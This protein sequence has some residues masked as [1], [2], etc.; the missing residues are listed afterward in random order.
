MPRGLLDHS[1]LVLSVGLRGDRCPGEWKM[2]PFW[3]ELMRGPVKVL[4]SLK[5]FVG[6]NTGMTSEVVWDAL[7]DF[8][9]GILIQA[10][11]IKRQTKD[12]EK[13]FGERVAMADPTPDML[14]DWS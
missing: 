2:S 5:A 11:K 13:S 8:L 10:S 9:W 12:R 6:L 4:A 1:P 14:R 3:M 7:K